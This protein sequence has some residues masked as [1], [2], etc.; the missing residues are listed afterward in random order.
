MEKKTCVWCKK[1]M[2]NSNNT[3]ANGNSIHKKC[4]KEFKNYFKQRKK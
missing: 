2:G 1:P 4:Q 3:S